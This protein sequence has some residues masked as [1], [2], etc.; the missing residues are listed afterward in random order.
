MYFTPQIG[1]LHI[2]P[3]NK[4]HKNIWLCAFPT[5][6]QNIFTTYAN[7]T[8][9]IAASSL[10]TS[11]LL[12]HRH[13]HRSFTNAPAME[14]NDGSEG[15]RHKQEISISVYF[16]LQFILFSSDPMAL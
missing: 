4:Y 12:A 3:Y 5:K 11:R 14:G 8:P 9:N 6:V 16:Q 15:N 1:P 2:K 13:L 10:A 7:T